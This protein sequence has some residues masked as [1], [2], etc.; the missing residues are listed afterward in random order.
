MSKSV[1]EMSICHPS[2][3]LDCLTNIGLRFLSA[4]LRLFASRPYGFTHSR[5]HSKISKIDVTHESNGF[6][7]L[8]VT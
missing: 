4:C 7:F 5:A 8:H 6:S 3:V 1:N 2:M